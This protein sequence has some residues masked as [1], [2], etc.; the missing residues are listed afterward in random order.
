[1]KQISFSEAE[2]AGKKRVTRRE[3]FL[4]EMERV[5]PWQEVLAV[6]ESHYPKGKR[7]RPPI[8]LERMLRVYLVQHWYS[9]SDEGVE[10]AITDS[11]ALRGFVGIDLS[12]ESAPDATTLLQFRHLLEEKDLSKA[13]FAAI[14]AQLTAKGLM[15]REGTIADATILAAPPSVKNEAKARDPEM[16]QTKKGNQWHFGMKAHIGVDADSGLVHTVVGTAANAADV[17]QTAEVL[18]GEETTV[19]LDAGYTG[20]EKR[21]ELKDRD[22]DW[23]VA[24]KRSK[25]KAIPKE[26]QLGP[27]LR[28]LE[29]VKASIRS[30]V[31]HPFHIVKNLFSHRK[32]RYKGLKKNTAQL[33]I[34]FALAN[35]VI[36]K[37]QLLALH[38]QDAS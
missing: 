3:R 36:A 21:E 17:T 19:Y 11:Q 30:K 29:S 10:D 23:Q 28:R 9:L 15:M 5:I 35:L 25:L 4:A 13:I 31:E 12:R 8:G 7:D 24:T 1:M 14:N 38:S 6:I 18:H 22:I 16:H 34:L 32:V 33:H 2:F 27:L 26:S 20:V 37:R